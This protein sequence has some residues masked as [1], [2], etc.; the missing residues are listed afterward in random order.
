MCAQLTDIFPP[1]DSVSLF[2]YLILVFVVRFRYLSV[3][4]V[5]QGGRTVAAEK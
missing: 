4:L 1:R 2:S 3:N 5:V